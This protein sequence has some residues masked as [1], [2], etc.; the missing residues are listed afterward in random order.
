MSCFITLDLRFG[1]NIKVSDGLINDFYHV[2]NMAIFI[3]IIGKNLVA[4][5]KVINYKYGG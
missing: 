4:L 5:P 1:I 2:T 3:L